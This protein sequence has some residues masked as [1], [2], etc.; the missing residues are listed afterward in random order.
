VRAVLTPHTELVWSGHLALEV[1]T[2]SPRPDLRHEGAETY[3]TLSID[4]GIGRDDLAHWSASLGGTGEPGL[5]H[6]DHDVHL[7]WANA[8]GAEA[9][10]SLFFRFVAASASFVGPIPEPGTVG[11]MLAGLGVLGMVARRRMPPRQAGQAA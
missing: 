9:G 8:T 10:A 11:L 1:E 6:A 5:L 7:S 3:A 4:N 2:D